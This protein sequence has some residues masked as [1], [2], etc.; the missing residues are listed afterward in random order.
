MTVV[1]HTN[2][3]LTKTSLG[4]LFNT[5]SIGLMFIYVKV[6]VIQMDGN[7][8]RDSITYSAMHKFRHPY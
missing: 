3:V 5:F 6:C 4:L 2:I 8:V 7:F 1:A